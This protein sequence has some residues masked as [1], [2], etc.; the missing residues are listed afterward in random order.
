MLSTILAL[1]GAAH[2]FACNMLSGYLEATRHHY[3]E[4]VAAGHLALPATLRLSCCVF[5]FLSYLSTR[6][7]CQI[8]TYYLT[9]GT[10]NRYS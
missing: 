3:R 7:K 2:L 9:I 4:R 6:A 10:I 1:G 5:Q 8:M